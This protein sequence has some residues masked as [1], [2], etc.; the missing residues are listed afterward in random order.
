MLSRITITRNGKPNEFDQ[1]S[2]G[3]I[4]KVIEHHDENFELYAQISDDEDH[5]NWELLGSFN[6]TTPEEYIINLIDTRLR[7][8][9]HYD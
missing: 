1:H 9:I 2:Y 6:N 4:C 8:N 5:P 7:K 3:A